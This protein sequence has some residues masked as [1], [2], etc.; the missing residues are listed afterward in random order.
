MATKS[1]A[2]KMNM[3]STNEDLGVATMS[4][5]S[6]TLPEIPE[7]I[8]GA[9]VHDYIEACAS[10]VQERFNSLCTRRG[11]EIPDDAKVLRTEQ[12]ELFMDAI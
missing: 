10:E 4:E 11:I 3:T 6:A 7:Y 1:S 9:F 8:T 5:P 12:V 2:P